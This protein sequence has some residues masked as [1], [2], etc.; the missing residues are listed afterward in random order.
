MF[1]SLVWLAGLPGESAIYGVRLAGLYVELS[2]R[3]LAWLVSESCEPDPNPCLGMFVG[4]AFKCLRG[5]V[6][7]FD[8]DCRG[9]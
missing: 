3:L 4:F 5:C 9:Y 7:V 8:F 6:V 2:S 1:I